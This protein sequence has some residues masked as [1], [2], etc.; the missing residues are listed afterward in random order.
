MVV[1]VPP[2]RPPLPCCRATVLIAVATAVLLTLTRRNRHHHRAE[3]RFPI[4]AV[5]PA[6]PLL[7]ESASM[8]MVQSRLRTPAA[9]SRRG[10]RLWPLALAAAVAWPFAQAGHDLYTTH[11]LCTTHGAVEHTEQHQ[12]ETA[13]ADDNHLEAAG[14]LRSA[15]AKDGTAPHHRCDA[16]VERRKAA[17]LA[18]TCSIASVPD[19]QQHDLPAQAVPAAQTAYLLLTAPKTSPPLLA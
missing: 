12:I 19:V 14:A 7:L 18:H 15:V 16:F 8:P 17:T 9:P 3:A 1:I 13:A 10:R 2:K 11:R 4:A 5:A 6:S